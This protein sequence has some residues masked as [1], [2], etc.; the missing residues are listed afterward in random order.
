MDEPKPRYTGSKPY[1]LIPYSD[2]DVRG[3]IGLPSTSLFGTRGFVDSLVHQ[4][5]SENAL[6]SAS[7]ARR[8]AQTHQ[9]FGNKMN[10]LAKGYAG[11]DA[12]YISDHLDIAQRELTEAW[13]QYRHEVV[14]TVRAGILG[15][16][17]GL[18][19]SFAERVAA[20]SEPEKENEVLIYSLL[21][22]SSQNLQKH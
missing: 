15:H 3:D 10:R 19:V 8:A 21:N 4:A 18:S 6:T 12:P 1:R 11:I 2:K 22:R 14:E 20:R 13:R 7:K 5:L 17:E 16:L 9:A